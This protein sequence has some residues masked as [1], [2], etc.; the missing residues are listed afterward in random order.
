MKR[1]SIPIACLLAPLLFNVACAYI[2][3]PEGL[4]AASSTESMGWRAVPTKVG[5]MEDGALRIDLA[6]LNETGDWSAMKAVEGAP[7]VLHAG[8]EDRECATVFVGTGGHRVAPGFQ[9]RG[10]IAG[11]KAEPELQPIYVECEGVSP[12]PG[13]TITLDY[14]YVTGQ[15]NYY[16]QDK[17]QVDTSLEVNLDQVIEDLAFPVGDPVDGLIQDA[18]TPMEAINKVTLELTD[19]QRTADGLEFT[20]KTANPG[21]YP[22]YVHIGNPPVIGEDGVLYGFYE[23][24]DIVSVPITPAG[25]VATWTTEVAVP[26]EVKGLIILLSVETGKARL[27]SNYAID[28]SD[29]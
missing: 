8:G 24:P 26:P 20:W 9:L 5:A 19:V 18:A 21:E 4:E 25:D 6:L 27:F 14:S 12:T 23:T 10:F 22:S 11:S 13:S 29:R 7:A 1:G 17:G 3:L 28:I 16:E 2:V 15:Y